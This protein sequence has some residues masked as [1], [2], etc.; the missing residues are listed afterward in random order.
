MN[1][2][3]LV[4]TNGVCVTATDIAP[5]DIAI[6]DEKI[7]LLS[8]SGFLKGART[9]RL[10]DADGGY[11]MPG[12]IDCHV[13]LQEPS[14]FGKGSSA[15]SYETGTRSAIAGGNT[16]IVAFAPQQKT[17]DSVLK[18]LENTHKLATGNSYCDYGL[19][20]LVSNPCAQ[21]LSEFKEL[22]TTEGVTS[23]KI[24]MTYA[25]LQLRDNEILSVLLAARQ[26]HILTMIHAEN[27]DVLDWLT[28]QLES[29]GKFAPK[30]HS[31]SRPPLLESEA[32]NRAI[33][34]SS[35]IANTPILLVHISDPAAAL[36][37]RQAQTA[38]Q[39]I[40]AETCPQYLL[41]TRDDLDKP[42]FEGA[43]CVCSPP[44][45]NVEDQ[46]QIWKGLKNGTFA[47]LSSDH[48]PFR[49][50]DNVTGK[51]TCITPEY[52]VGKFR[53]IPNGLPGIE[54]RL[55]LAFSARKLALNKFVEVSSTNAAKL[56]GL[57]PRKGSIIPGVSDAD[58]VIW[59]PNGKLEALEVTN[60]M[61]HH[62]ADY[63][64]YE[65]RRVDN[66]PRYTILRG[67]VVWD[68]DGEGIVG[69]KGYGQFIKRTPGIL[70]DIWQTVDEDGAFDLENL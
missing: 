66:W 24:Y 21:A 40:F 33:A 58:L 41:L 5:Y 62:A 19:H 18:A 17:E 34:L 32:T 23:L 35:L 16:T 1:E 3:D 68:R 64:P 56:Y 53:Y 11:V 60:S 54:T 4:I 12:G 36:R 15:D 13:H 47:V 28:D 49:Y 63:T 14:L 10:I 52:P 29:Q 25:A 65:G 39:P 50:E 45:R 22:A 67:K 48:C 6:K 26:N 7:V 31:N 42:G 70:N 27:G 69:A 61:L 8:P 2:Y 44:P 59:Y 38:G 46:L 9:T 55:P 30:Y 37:I 51:K 57:Y 20:L 43:K